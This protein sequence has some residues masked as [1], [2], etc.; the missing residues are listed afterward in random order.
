MMIMVNKSTMCDG[1]E[2]THIIYY[3]SMCVCFDCC[4]VSCNVEVITR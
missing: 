4:E 3:N 2:Y 1:E